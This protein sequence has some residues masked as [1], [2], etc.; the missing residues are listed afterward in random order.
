MK[1]IAFADVHGKLHDIRELVEKAKNEK[2]D[3]FLCA[4]DLTFFG[5]SLEELIKKF[6]IGIP[7][8][9]IPGNHELPDDMKKAA[10]KHDFVKNIHEN[11]FILDSCTFAGVGGSKITPFSTPF[12]QDDK[13]IGST[14]GK[15]KKKK[16]GKFIL[17]THEPPLSTALDYVG[18]LHLG[19]SAIRSFIE[20]TQPDFCICGHFHENAGKEDKIGKTII[21]NPNSKGYTIKI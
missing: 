2:A 12:E 21:I 5:S 13:T 15:L 14:L 17:V 19:S 18:G 7:L 16:S 10:K 1:I 4:G 9:I 11:I 8:I 3:A 6:N 20:K